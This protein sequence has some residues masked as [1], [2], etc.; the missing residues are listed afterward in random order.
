MFDKE[1]KSPE[2]KVKAHPKEYITKKEA[3]ENKREIEIKSIENIPFIVTIMRGEGNILF[4]AKKREDI[5][6]KIY[7]KNTVLADFIKQNK[8]F[9][10]F[11]N[12]EELFTQYLM[13]LEI[14]EITLSFTKNTVIIKITSK[15]RKKTIET[16]ILLEDEE[17]KIDDSE[18][19]AIRKA[20]LNELVG[21]MTSNY[22]F[23]D[24]CENSTKAKKIFIKY[25]E[26]KSNFGTFFSFNN[27]KVNDRLKYYNLNIGDIY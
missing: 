4:M 22:N 26:D 9:N 20:K 1:G 19:N 6:T 24:E 2:T 21:Q 10:Q 13:D 15:A 11:D 17:T 5:K 8:Y 12:N 16:N 3:K 27:K 14:K 23:N 7:K 18:N 25:I